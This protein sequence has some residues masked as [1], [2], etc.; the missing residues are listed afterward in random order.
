MVRPTEAVLFRTIDKKKPT[1]LLDEIDTIY[2]TDADDRSEGLRAVLNAGFQS[3][4]FSY[5][6]RCIGKDHE[7]ESFCTFC[8]KVIAGIGK[9]LPDTVKDRSIE[10]RLM[11]Q[12]A[13]AKADRFRIADVEAGADALRD[14]LLAWSTAARA[15]LAEAR[16]KMPEQLSDR[17]QD[18]M[19]CLFAIADMGGKEWAEK[20]RHSLVSLGASHE[21]QSTGVRLLVDCREIFT[22]KSK[23]KLLTNELIEGLV[24]IESADSPWPGWWEESLR[25]NN[26]KSPA[27][28]LAKLLTPFNIKPSTVR[29]DEGTAKGYYRGDFLDAWKRYLEPVKAMETKQL[30]LI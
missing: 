28:K 4:P 27:M 12:T 2:T 7:P 26:Y 9:N 13:D 1:L 15:E 29:L 6:P 22:A 23:D 18:M 3:G 21:D 24:A 30:G 25:R 16:P 8:P 14:D 17:Q 5:I 20:A 10:I 11:R 19:E